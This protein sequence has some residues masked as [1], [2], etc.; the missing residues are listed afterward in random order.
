MP[1]SGS[2]TGTAIPAG[3]L[4]ALYDLA[5]DG[6]N[7]FYARRP[8]ATRLVRRESLVGDMDGAN[9]VFLTSQRPF[10]EDSLELYYRNTTT[11]VTPASVD[12]DGGV[13]ILPNAPNAPITGDYTVVPM[14][15]QQVVNVAWAGYELMQFLWTRAFA[16][17]SS[18]AVY[19]RAVLDDAHIYIVTNDGGAVSDPVIGDSTFYE[20]QLQR[21][22]LSWC[23]E[24]AYLDSL[25]SEAAASDIMIR[26]R[27]GGVSIDPSRRPTN[28]VEAKRVVWD[29]LL[30]ALNAAM[31]ADPA[32]AGLQYGE[33]VTMPHT[34]DYLENW[35]W[36]DQQTPWRAF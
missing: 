19:L 15:R 27:A 24:Y 1:S 33:A 35:R 20:S 2:G 13:I 11:A 16:L 9:I 17:S 12:A 25:T 22:L 18:S 36:Q 10:L 29:Q 14:T 8:G 26:E 6:V 28:L 23:I 34:Q 3:G 5:V 31:D 30:R 4:A 7:D 32:A 21:S